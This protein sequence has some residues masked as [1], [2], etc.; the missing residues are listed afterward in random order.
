M[1]RTCTF[2][3]I[4]I[5]GYALLAGQMPALRAA[6]DGFVPLFAGDSL[7]GWQVSDWSNIS[8]PQKVQGTPWRIEK[9]V[10]YGL[11]KRTWITSPGEYSDFIL[12]LES[13]IGKGAN[14]GIGLRFPLDGDPAYT[15]MELQVVDHEVYYGGQSTPAQ[16]TASIYDEIAASPEV[17]KP[18]GQWNVWEITAKGSHVTVVLNGQ[19]VI[20]ADLSRETKARQQKGPALAQRPLKGHIGFQNLN[21]EITLRNIMIKELGAEGT[22]AGEKLFR[23]GMIGLDTS[24][25]TAFTKQINDPAKNYGCKVVAGYAGGSPD[26]P[27]SANRVE[28]FTKQLREQFGVEIVQSIEEL[29]QKVDGVMLE[30]VDGRPHLSQARPVIAAKKPVFIDKPM[31]GNLSDVL[32]IF[33]LARE[34]N[35]PCWSSSSL[36]FSPTLADIRESEKFG[37][38]LGCDVFS[39]CS[40]EEHHPDL[41]WYGV[42]G[43][44]MLFT[45]MG[46]GCQTVSRVHTKDTDVVVGVW[47][48]GRIGTYRGLRAG[49]TDYG[50]SIFG[51]KAVGPIGASAGYGPLIDEIVK[52]FKTGKSPVPAEETMEI[53]AF[54]SAADESKARGGAE[55]SIASV[56]EKAKPRNK[57]RG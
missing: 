55:V 54:M 3:L 17:T 28:G 49:K 36:R 12:K 2:F 42:H 1:K 30:S 57:L 15:A 38:V 37:K 20:D 29:C 14:G 41:Y 50:A 47:K 35:V 16:R 5:L 24:H 4:T 8:T 43:V 23:I 39:P 32:E 9:G 34:N 21:G 31:A 22:R 45:I 19:K 10:L 13:K 27:D 46:T 18:P 25:V 56:I 33:R 40:L 52:F 26:V 53:F 6:E 11:N 51:T 44:E 7:Q 48:D